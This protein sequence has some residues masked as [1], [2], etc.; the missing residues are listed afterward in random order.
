MNT[1]I[2]ICSNSKLEKEKKAIVII[3]HATKLLEAF[4][5][6]SIQHSNSSRCT[7]QLSLKFTDSDSLIGCKFNIFFLEST[8]VTNYYESECSNFNIFYDFLTS[9]TPEQRM[10]FGFGENDSGQ[11]YKYTNTSKRYFILF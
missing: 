1:V 8:R 2:A 10:R 4:T 7:K 3:K 11:S 6:A 5:S 9:I